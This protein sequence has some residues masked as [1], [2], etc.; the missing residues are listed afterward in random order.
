MFSGTVQGI[1][2][3]ARRYGIQIVLAET[4]YGLGEEHHAVATL[5]GRRVD[6]FIIVGV[7][8]LP[9]TLQIL[10]QSDLPVVDTWDTTRTPINSITALSNY[11]AAKALT[12]VQ[13]LLTR[14]ASDSITLP[15]ENGSARKFRARV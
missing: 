9:E 1:G 13:Y 12:P 11:D 5:L 10:T 8:H 15:I 3:I 2:N 14:F 4:D 7:H 6:G